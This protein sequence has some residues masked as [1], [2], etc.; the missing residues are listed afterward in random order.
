MTFH[1]LFT[2][3]SGG[4]S[5]P[6]YASLDLAYHVGDDP[7]AVK[8]N[9]QIVQER[10]GGVPIVWM[11]QV[12]GKGVRYVA[13]AAR[14]TLPACDAL[15][16][17]RPD[18]ALAVM[19]ADCMPVLMIDRSHHAVA[20]VH[21]G[22]NGLFLGILG[23]TFKEMATR[24]GTRGSDLEVVTGP[25]IGLC[26]Y[27]VSEEIAVIARKNFGPR[28][29]KGCHLDLRAIATAQL[30]ELGVAKERI[31][32]SPTCT[33]CSMAHYSYRRDGRT[34]RFA[35]LVWMTSGLSSPRF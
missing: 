6:P 28:A 1:T 25:S 2:D 7:E 12:H 10:I 14:D 22:R 17:D 24:F 15:I 21:A 35:G 34:G 18:I 4:F 20:A 8:R 16:T 5:A 29:A 32:L 26:C 19:V 3:R 13:D 23:E 33:A 27:E 30:L 11:E 31:D 9:R